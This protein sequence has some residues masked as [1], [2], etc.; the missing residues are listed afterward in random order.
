GVK[1]QFCAA[2]VDVLGNGLQGSEVL[3]LIQRVTCLL[4][5]LFVDDDAEGLVAVADGLQLASLVV[6]V[7]VVGGQL[8]GDGAVRQVQCVVVPVL[9]AGQVADVENG[10][11]FGLAHLSGQG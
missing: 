3:D 2:G 7:K 10:G 8:F 4:Q 5:E 1:A 6:E 11:G 9:Q